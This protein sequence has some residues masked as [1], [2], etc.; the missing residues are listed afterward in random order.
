MYIELKWKK[1]GA[2]AQLFFHESWWM[3]WYS[4]IAEGR[5]ERNTTATGWKDG[6]AN[7]TFPW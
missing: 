3:M 5:R 7:K 2:G 6:I 4:T 1:Q